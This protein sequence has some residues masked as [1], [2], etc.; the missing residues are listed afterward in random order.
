MELSFRVWMCGGSLEIIPCSRVGHVFRKRRPYGSSP[1]EEDTM[2]RNSLRVAKVWMDDYITNYFEVNSRAKN[3]YYGNIT[4]RI[5]LR[6]RLQCK[7][8]KWYMENVY[9][10]MESSPAS[11]IGDNKNTNDKTKTKKDGPKYERWDQRYIFI[12]L[13]SICILLVLIS[14][15]LLHNSLILKNHFSTQPFTGLE[16]TFPS[17]HYV[18]KIRNFVS[19]A[20]VVWEKKKLDW[21]LPT[22][23]PLR[24]ANLGSELIGMN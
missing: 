8:F 9:P 4:D 19:R 16:I 15:I 14:F 12:I 5:E 3:V 23:Y 24:K 18:S 2:T 21:F 6:K 22:V 11:S 1:G 17:S 20:M 7:D 13:D 10:D